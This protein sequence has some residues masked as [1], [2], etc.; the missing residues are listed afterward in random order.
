MKQ[1]SFSVAGSLVAWPFGT[2]FAITILSWMQ[3][4]HFTVAFSET[5]MYFKDFCACA[6]ERSAKLLKLVILWFHS[7]NRKIL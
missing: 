3:F 2:Q 1:F 6:V 7:A 5:P 4:T